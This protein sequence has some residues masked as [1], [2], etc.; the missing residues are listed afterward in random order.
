MV[1]NAFSKA[2][3]EPSKLADKVEVK[4]V[5]P[6]PETPKVEETPQSETPKVEEPAER[7]PVD[8]LFD[9]TTPTT[10]QEPESAPEP[11]QETPQQETSSEDNTEMEGKALDAE[12]IP[13]HLEDMDPTKVNLPAQTIA[14]AVSTPAPDR[15]MPNRV[16]P[17]NVLR[18][19]NGNVV[20]KMST[21]LQEDNYMLLRNISTQLGVPAQAVINALVNEGLRE[22][23]CDLHSVWQYLQPRK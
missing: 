15:L 11:E 1:L 22:K 5:E 20:R 4:P 10:P 13:D 21:R 12:T 17:T 9:S 6:E 19:G 8:S 2:A 18:L 16:G 7:R 23:K 14:R 3:S